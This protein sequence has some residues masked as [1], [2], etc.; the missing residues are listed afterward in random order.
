MRLLR[1]MWG[2][3]GLTLLSLT[4]VGTCVSTFGD[5]P[6]TL[7]PGAL[8]GGVTLLPNGWKIAPAGRHVQVGSLPLAM[9]ES[10]DGRSLLIASNG[11][12]KP[13]ITVVDIKSQ[14]VSD[15]IV[16]DHAWLG[17]A[18]HPDGKRLY[19][20]GAGNNTVH[21][22]R[23]NDLRP[24]ANVGSDD[25][26]LSTPLPTPRYVRGPDLVLGRPMEVPLPGSNRPEPVPQSFIGGIAITPDG[27]RL[28]A[29]HVLGQVVSAV[30]LKTGRVL[31]TIDLPAEPYTCLVSP[32]GKTLFVSLWGGAKILL[33][34]A[35]SFA[36]R[37]EIAV[38][39]HPN[40]M[41]IT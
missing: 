40:A 20:S 32:D 22:L 5:L 31:H 13:A 27:T 14:R 1:G 17:L 11:F 38:G 24:I 33:F 29:V 39:E 35:E 34:D 37:G 12:M 26:T 41:A 4:A 25:E 8:G 19:V 30:D 9:V 6:A 10:P 18:W 3:A 16:L 2:R 28:F 23:V 21:E 7:R 36:A 15:V